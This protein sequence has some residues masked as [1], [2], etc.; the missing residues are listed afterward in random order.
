MRRKRFVYVGLARLQVYVRGVLRWAWQSRALVASLF[1]GLLDKG[2]ARR[3]R[4]ALRA[5]GWAQLAAVPRLK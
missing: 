2:Q 3:V 5:G 1:L 4:K